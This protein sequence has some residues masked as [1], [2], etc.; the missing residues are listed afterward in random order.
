MSFTVALLQVEPFGMD[1]S[2]NLEKGLKCCRDAKL[3]GADLVVFPELWNIGFAQC[4]IDVTGRQLWTTSAID[5]HGDF[6]RSF[7]DLAQELDLNVAITY[8]EAHMPK[9]RNTVSIINHRGEVVLNYSKVFICD[10]GQ[11]E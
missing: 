7:V 1:Q 11:D 6:F 8:L 5:R 4:P 2:R 10:F 9:P 3:M